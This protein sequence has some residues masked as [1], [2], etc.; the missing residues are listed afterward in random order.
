MKTIPFTQ[1]LLP[2]GEKK[3]ITIDLPDECWDKFLELKAAGCEMTAEVLRTGECSFCI[4]CPS[5]EGDFDCTV[6]TNG[7]GVAEAILKMILDFKIEEF[8][9][10][11]VE[12]E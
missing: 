3:Q 12:M 2:Y 5:V 6:T 7:P 9:A 11:K 8:N 10:W 1:Y 4:A